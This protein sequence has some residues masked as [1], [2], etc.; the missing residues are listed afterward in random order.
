M[1]PYTYLDKRICPNCN[2]PIPDQFHG[3]Q[4]FCPREVREDNTVKNC[5]D[6][7]W[8][9]KNR[10]KMAPFNNAAIF[11]RDQ[12]EAVE[13]LYKS[14]GKSVT[15]EDI[16]RFGINLFRPMEFRTT[17]SKQFEFYFYQYAIKQLSNN[18]F[19]ILTHELF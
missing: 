15:L 11:Q 10:E 12:F 7:Y 2:N 6:D 13:A 8:S 17:V 18:Q 14:K 9:K 19:E 5:K 4:K 3:L 1:S 16:N